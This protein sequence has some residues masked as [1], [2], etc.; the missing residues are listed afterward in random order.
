MKRYSCKL[1]FQWSPKQTGRARSNARVVEER[2][3]SFEAL[4]VDAALSESKRLGRE[5][6]VFH[7]IE[8]QDVKFQ[9]VGVLE[10]I[11][12][13]ENTPSSEVWVEVKD[14]AAKNGTLSHLIPKE[15]SLGAI[16][17]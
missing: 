5:N 15:C 14:G 3:Y 2:I 9:F 7:D 17:G 16:R 1:L 6:E 10:L 11:Q 12:L 4:S 8:N 13:T